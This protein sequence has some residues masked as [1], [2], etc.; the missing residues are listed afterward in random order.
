MKD[1]FF[2]VASLPHAKAQT[3]HAVEI[4]V[5]SSRGLAAAAA[6]VRVRGGAFPAECGSSAAETI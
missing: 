4:V 5:L 6:A 3:E 2:I 1:G